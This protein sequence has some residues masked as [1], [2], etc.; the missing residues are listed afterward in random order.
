MARRTPAAASL[1]PILDRPD[2]L[3]LIWAVVSTE[4]QIRRCLR[5][6]PG[7][8]RV[9]L[10]GSRAT[11][12][13]GPLSD[14]DF[15]IS[16]ADFDAVR[17][18]IPQA[19]APLHPLGALW[20]PLSR[21]ANFMLVLDGPRKVDLLFD[22]PQERQPPWTPT[23]GSLPL[24]DCHFWDWTLW[25][26]AKSLARQDQLVRDELAT[27][28]GFILQPLGVAEPPTSLAHAVRTYRTS[29]GRLETRLGVRVSRRL[30]ESV[31]TALA[32]NGVQGL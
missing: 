19:V 18:A 28:S 1:S 22:E 24:I 6:T 14:W 17:R 11:G 10:V 13:A 16:T 23:A 5:G 30:G 26:G 25:L 8:V 27:M 2:Q 9:D 31:T 21:R 12:A 4:Q 20:D 3:N 32:R 29:R 15:A 7:I